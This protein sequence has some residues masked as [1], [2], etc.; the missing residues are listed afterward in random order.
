MYKMNGCNGFFSCLTE[1]IVNTIYASF[2]CSAGVALGFV[3]T[4]MFVHDKEP[5]NIKD[6]SD[7]ESES[8]A[9]ED[10]ESDSV[11]YC[12]KYWEDYNN[13]TDKDLSEEDIS[14]IEK[15]LVIDNL[16]FYGGIHMRYNKEYNG[17]HYY[18]DRGAN[19]PYKMLATVARKFVTT[20]NCK[21]LYINL[22]DELEKS[23]KVLEEV[24]RRI[25]DPTEEEIQESVFANLKKTRENG[26][27]KEKK[28][29]YLIKGN[30][31]K[32]KYMGKVSDVEV[33]KKKL[34]DETVETEN[35]PKVIDFATFKN[36]F[37]LSKTDK[38]KDV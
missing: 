31:I 12:K 37:S 17:Y 15:C 19:I 5:D 25:K 6:E 9:E 7:T 1:T 11:K 8:E 32:F 35:K 21:S 30:F 2:I 26:L 22:T 36:M 34:E 16:P 23:K 13:L 20:F 3:V 38:D 4:A 14:R 29:E 28:D 27:S 33:F 10:N 18:N 24:E